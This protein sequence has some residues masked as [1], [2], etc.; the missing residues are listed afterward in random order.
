MQE[1]TATGQ[2][3]TQQP[4]NQPGSNG[5]PQL[6]TEQMVDALQKRSQPATPTEDDVD[7][8]QQLNDRLDRAEIREMERQRQA[9]TQALYPEMSDSQYIEMRLAEINGETGKAEKIRL[10]AAKRGMEVSQETRKQELKDV[11]TE[12]AGSGATDNPGLPKNLDDAE[13]RA[14]ARFGN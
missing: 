4:T 14:N 5:T 13:S 3:P 1:P 9:E 12:G 2:T 7:P 10:D 8:V 11:H 6:T